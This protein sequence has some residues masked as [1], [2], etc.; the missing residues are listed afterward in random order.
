MI[1]HRKTIACLPQANGAVESF[2]KTLHKRL[3]KIYNRD[4]DDWDEK[5][6]GLI[7]QFISSQQG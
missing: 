4:K 3:L 7:A 5:F 6:P 2:N 1:E